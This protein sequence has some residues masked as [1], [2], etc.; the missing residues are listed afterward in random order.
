MLKKFKNHTFITICIALSSALCFIGNSPAPAQS[1]GTCETSMTVFG[2]SAPYCTVSVAPK[3]AG[4]V[5]AIPFNEGEAVK[6]GEVILVL[7]KTDYE[8]Q[9]DFAKT[10]VE[11]AKVALAQANLELQRL[12]ELV[13]N[14]SASVQSKD[15]ATFAKMSA[16]ANLNA[17]VASLRIAENSLANATILS[18][19]NGFVSIKYKEYG[20][21]VDKGKPVYDLVSLDVIKAKLKIPELMLPKVKKGDIVDIS[22]DSYPD[23]IFKGEISE[24]KPVGDP[25]TH[26]FEVSAI[27][28]N[29]DYKL[30]A[31]MFLKASI[32]SK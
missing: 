13:K 12:S 16:Q 1:Q 28:K 22:V 25:L 31:G 27:I 8:L 15:N 18:P 14:N 21:F 6:S 30:K 4:T 29:A 24:I 2:I 5:E 10:Q 26:F 17:A 3:I 20:D 32:T 11:R 19:L 7:E 23:T 9:V